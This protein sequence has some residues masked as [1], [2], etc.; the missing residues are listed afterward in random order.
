MAN[1]TKA[2]EVLTEGMKKLTQIS[3]MFPYPEKALASLQDVRKFSETWYLVFGIYT[4]VS[5]TFAVILNV[6]LI[7]VYVRFCRSKARASAYNLSVLNLIISDLLMCIGSYPAMVHS[8]FN[9]GWALG[10]VVC[11]VCA[12]V[13]N[14]GALAQIGILLEIAFGRYYHM[15]KMSKYRAKKCYTVFRLSG[16]W[17][18]A[19]ILAGAVPLFG[20]GSFVPDAMLISCSF[21]YNNGTKVDMAYCILLL[22]VGYIV[23]SLALYLLY[24]G[25]MSNN[26]TSIDNLGTLRV[27]GRRRSTLTARTRKLTITVMICV[28]AFSVSWTPYAVGVII[29]LFQAKVSRLYM[30]FAVL[31]A[32]LSTGMNAVIYAYRSSVLREHLK[33]LFV[34]PKLRA[35]KC[36][37]KDS[38]NLTTSHKNM[39]L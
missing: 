7:V 5:G 17:A 22:L 36:C 39:E 12:A 35:R 34:H 38:N 6:L 29:S 16:I 32:K 13:S 33:Q 23:P 28:V 25:V 24:L 31:L 9:H 27:H 3:K 30:T 8:A 2:K 18:I 26:R 4:A 1:I 37:T 11:Q 20:F 10:A 14:T 21:N 15:Q 19:G